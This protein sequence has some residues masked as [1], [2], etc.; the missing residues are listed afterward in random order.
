MEEKLRKYGGQF[1]EGQA[2]R[3]FAEMSA[4]AQQDWLIKVA[5]HAANVAADAEESEGSDA[6]VKAA[7]AHRA[8]A[9][10]FVMLCIAFGRDWDEEASLNPYRGAEEIVIPYP[11]RRLGRL[12]PKS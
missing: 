9:D 4:E 7:W 12:Q 10:L 8:C 3:R 11:G 6:I 2:Y 5:N 1:G